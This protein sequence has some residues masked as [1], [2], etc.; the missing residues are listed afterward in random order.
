VRARPTSYVVAGVA[1]LSALAVLARDPDPLD[2]ADKSASV[3]SLIVAVIALYL[4]RRKDSPAGEA[5]DEVA[6]KLAEHVKQQ[7]QE[8]IG[9]RLL[10]H[11][12]PLR[13]RWSPSQPAAAGVP[14]AKPGRL[15]RDGHAARH[16]VILVRRTRPGQLVVLGAPGSGKSSLMALF[17]VDAIDLRQTGDPVPVLLA[18]PTWDPGE[19]LDKWIARR[20]DEDYPGRAGRL[21][22]DR[23]I[24]PVLDGLDELPGPALDRA[25]DELNRIA[26]TLPGLIVTSRPGEYNK[27]VSGRGPLSTAAVVRIEPV[28]PDDAIVFLTESDLRGS[29]R[30]QPIAENLR[31]DRAGD[32]A[33]T[34]ANPLMISLARSAYQ[35]PQSD[36]RRL[37]AMDGD[38]LEQHLLEEYLNNA[39]PGA[40]PRRWLT[41]LATGTRMRWWTL[42][43]QVHPAVIVATIGLVVAALGA[44]AG[45]GFAAL[46]GYRPGAATAYAAVT[47]LALG[48][49]AGRRAARVHEPSG[50]FAIVAAALRDGVV[51]GAI[52]AAGATVV[53]MTATSDPAVEFF[54]PFGVLG[55]VGGT[56]LGII[57]NGLAAGRRMVPQRFGRRL[58]TLPRR[59]AD[60]CLTASLFALPAAAVIAALAAVQR[61][62][63]E[64]G[65]LAV[66]PQAL[67]DTLV[68]GVGGALVIGLPIG[69]GRWLSV[70]GE[71]AE[72]APHPPTA[73]PT[74]TTATFRS[75]LRVERETLLVTTAGAALAVG[76]VTA[77]VVGLA[78]RGLAGVGGGSPAAAAAV[79][80]GLA[81]V[82][83]AVLAA[84]GSGAPWVAYT[85]A[86]LWLAAR[87]RLP[88]DLTGFLE[89]AHR[90]EVLRQDGPAYRFRHD[91]LR[92]HLAGDP[93][94]TPKPD[95]STVRRRSTVVTAVAGVVI[96]LVTG[97]TVVP[98][99]V[100]TVGRK[101]AA[102]ACRVSITVDVTPAYGEALTLIVDHFNQSRSA[103]CQPVRLV[104][105]SRGPLATPDPDQAQ[106]WIP[107]SS[108]VV[109]LFRGRSPGAVVGSDTDRLVYDPLVLAVPEPLAQRFDGADWPEVA[110]Y[111]RGPASPLRVV[112]PNPA[113]SI[114][115]LATVHGFSRVVAGGAVDFTLAE[116]RS[117]EVRRGVAE[118]FAKATITED[119]TSFLCAGDL[120]ADTVVITRQV[121]ADQANRG[122]SCQS[123]PPAVRWATVRLTNSGLPADMPFAV[124]SSASKAQSFL[125]D[126]FREFLQDSIAQASPHQLGEQ[127]PATAIAGSRL[128]P[129]L[130]PEIAAMWDAVRPPVT[131]VLL[132]DASGSMN[133]PTG[134]LMLTAVREGLTWLRPD[135]R[136]GLWT[137]STRPG[138]NDPGFRAHVLTG[139]AVDVR[140]RVEQ[141]L[142]RQQKGGETPLHA[143]ILGV[144]QHIRATEP[145][146]RPVNLVVVTDGQDTSQIRAREVVDA[147]RRQDGTIV[148]IIGINISAD[149]GVTAGLT[150]ISEASGGGTFTGVTSDEA[151]EALRTA[152]TLY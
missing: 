43:T 151:A 58:G 4:G 78:G 70:P 152:F 150:A 114:T 105:S 103:V 90:R 35:S 81:A 142:A 136:L 125:A 53:L 21:V 72:R 74:G 2:L 51:S 96:L 144:Q 85:I 42:A 13:L 108:S 134:N 65:W 62:D 15:D 135:D 82:L 140:E 29:T 139:P 56:M 46:S 141:E 30:W 97:V 93:P 40:E 64:R 75:S 17:V 55:V 112:V 117:P 102:T 138:G 130:L 127:P 52:F 76:V 36:P 80:A 86:R 20:I 116:V 45:A 119:V 18:L 124:L 131:S 111:L 39:Y 115:G 100:G 149:R 19:P 41:V 26:P 129:E 6:R 31:N 33:T 11:P 77:S 25:F 14:P 71:V 8:E 68:I 101:L 143:A 9:L 146:T 148:R 121:I 57:S 87:G 118:L 67:L 24:L 147:V 89:A 109:D 92:S 16:L 47:G 34:F 32:L 27:V 73:P 28:P 126:A 37:L 99:A 128:A 83:V 104:S 91:R 145:P 63:P 49:L 107:G 50:M 61:W 79:A 113:R 23:R 66:L 12:R 60:G 22:R 84:F 133:G 98:D 132:V 48:V 120:S 44:A 54:G 69:V 137:F 7:W 106:V 123:G 59:L 1:L 122:R 110:S 3:L 95:R 88:R 10:Q 94:K 5:D 38:T